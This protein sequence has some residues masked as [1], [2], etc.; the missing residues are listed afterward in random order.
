MGLIEVI[1]GAELGSLKIVEQEGMLN[2]EIT[3]RC[4]DKQGRNVVLIESL[5]VAQCPIPEPEVCLEKEAPVEPL[6]E[7]P[8]TEPAK[9]QGWFAKMFNRNK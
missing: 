6:V 8:E 2:N 5:I 1:P 4:E 9:K 3:W 7:E